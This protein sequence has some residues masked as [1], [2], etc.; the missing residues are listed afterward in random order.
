MNF[1]NIMYSDRALGQI[2]LVDVH[3]VNSAEYRESTLKTG[4]DVLHCS[5]DLKSDTSVHTTLTTQQR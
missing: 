5:E 1:P 2:S 4:Q 3:R